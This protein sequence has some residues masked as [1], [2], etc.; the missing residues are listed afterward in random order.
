[1]SEQ[2]PKTKLLKTASGWFRRNTAR[3]VIIL[4]SL[5]ILAVIVIIPK[6][7]RDVPTC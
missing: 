6:R 5:A 4:A 3:K 1:M 7:N 2:S